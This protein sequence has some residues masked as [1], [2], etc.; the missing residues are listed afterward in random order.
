[1]GPNT[2]GVR[3]NLWDQEGFI[4]MAD[5]TWH[6]WYDND[7]CKDGNV[8]AVPGKTG[9]YV[10]NYSTNKKGDPHGQ[11]IY[12]STAPT[13]Y[14]PWSPAT[15]VPPYHEDG[16]LYKPG[17]WDTIM[18]FSYC[19]GTM[20]G[21]WTATPADGSVGFGYGTSTDGLHWTPLPPAQV[22]LPGL[23]GTQ[24]E[25]GG[26][27]RL[28][29]GRWY[30]HA[31]ATQWGSVDGW[32]GCFNVVAD[33]PGGP[34]NRTEKN[35]AL[36][37][38][39]NKGSP[40]PSEG[41]PAYFSRPF[42]GP[43]GM[44]LVNHIHRG[45]MSTLK[46]AVVGDDG[47]MRWAWWDGNEALRGPL[48]HLSSD[49]ALPTAVV[50]HNMSVE[51]A[52]GS[53]IEGEIV[54]GSDADTAAVLANPASKADGGFFRLSSEAGSRQSGGTAA[55]WSTLD[56]GQFPA[57]TLQPVSQW[58]RSTYQ[59]ITTEAPEPSRGLILKS[60]DKVGWRLLM[61]QGL[62]ESYL[63]PPPGPLTNVAHVAPEFFFAMAYD[64]GPNS[65]ALVGDD[66]FK[67]TLHLHGA[68]A[69]LPCRIYAMSLDTHDFTPPH[70]V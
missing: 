25:V 23:S 60:G 14:G 4:D 29:D 44:P 50:V 18:Q 62:Y 3:R 57:S 70:V 27:A 56:L 1:M 52:H 48:V 19:N 36:L 53:I 65:V 51:V 49:H 40:I 68:F 2:T 35:W 31:C 43:G 54:W 59:G 34:Y 41:I 55:V 7:F 64:A 42:L 6:M 66:Q 28:L 63:A 33:E 69:Q 24:V 13:P 16:H 37:A 11:E 9:K 39:A 8:W 21:W 58:P 32:G 30:A 5:G 26:V 45:H 22:H 15:S 10:V 47:V 12:F 67:T 46:R 38:Y 20:L 61:R 17:R